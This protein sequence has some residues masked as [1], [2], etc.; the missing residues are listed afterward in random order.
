[1]VQWMAIAAVFMACC[2]KIYNDPLVIGK[3][4]FESIGE[5]GGCPR[6]VRSGPGSENRTMAAIQCYQRADAEDDLAGEKA[7]RYGPSTGNQRI[8]CF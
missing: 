4:S 6:L 7:H 1:M 5:I 2:S 8:E 3:H